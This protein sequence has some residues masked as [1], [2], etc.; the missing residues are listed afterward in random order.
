MFCG[1]CTCN[2]PRSQLRKCPAC[3]RRVC[4]ACMG[5][6]RDCRRDDKPAPKRHRVGKLW[7]IVSLTGLVGGM[8]E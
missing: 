7:C 5:N 8:S 3:G 6:H 2:T 1:S 4:E